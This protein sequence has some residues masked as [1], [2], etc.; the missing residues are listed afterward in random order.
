MPTGTKPKRVVKQ[1]EIDEGTQ[2]PKRVL[3][4]SDT[5]DDMTKTSDL[6]S[7]SKHK[8]D[9][10]TQEEYPIRKTSPK[11]VQSG[12][13][14]K[15]K[16][17]AELKSS[18]K[19]DNY[20][21]MRNPTMAAEVQ[22]RTTTKPKRASQDAATKDDMTKTSKVKTTNKDESH[23][24][25]HEEYSHTKTSLKTDKQQLQSEKSGTSKKTK[26]EPEF[27]SSE[28]N[29]NSDPMRNPTRTAGVQKRTKKPKQASQD[30]DTKEDMTKTS[31]VKTTNKD[32]SHCKPHEEYPHTK[33][34]L[35]I[36]KQQLLTD[37]SGTSKKTKEEPEFTSSGK[38]DQSDP[39]RNSTTTS[40]V[41]KRTTEP[42]PALQGA[43]EDMT[44]STKVMST[45]REELQF[46][47]VKRNADHHKVSLK[48]HQIKKWEVEFVTLEKSSISYGSDV[49]HAMGHRVKLQLK[50]LS[51]IEWTM[52]PTGSYYDKTKVKFP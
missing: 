9:Y 42:Q 27:T 6:K 23:C 13:T 11:K 1:P 26:E 7:T 50:T 18:E 25:P 3:Q 45:N 48:I 46:C 28:K 38:S 21:P 52:F 12:A 15:A 8:S 14:K 37:K 47:S 49:I 5:R 4:D 19:S 33:T 2:E 44:K 51:G 20:D 10:T 30:A 17:K 39:K 32:E 43:D 40:E 16:G 29:D 34:S 41:Q 24:K 31:K 22:K 35:K 36:N